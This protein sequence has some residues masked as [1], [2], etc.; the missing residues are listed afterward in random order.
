MRKIKQIPSYVNKSL[1]C[2]LLNAYSC[3]HAPV[4][5][6]AHSDTNTQPVLHRDASCKGIHPAV[7]FSPNSQHPHTHTVSTATLSLAVQMCSFFFFSLPEGMGSTKVNAVISLHLCPVRLPVTA[8][9]TETRSMRI[10][11]TVLSEQ[12][13]K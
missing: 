1:F 9:S 8:G 10:S 3:R 13:T 5:G 11:L 12:V 7:I 6:L 4:R 2:S